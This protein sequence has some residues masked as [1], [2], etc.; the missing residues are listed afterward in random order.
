MLS[1]VALVFGAIMG[2]LILANIMDQTSYGMF[3]FPAPWKLSCLGSCQLSSS[4]SPCCAGVLFGLVGGI[5]TWIAIKELLP[6]AYRYDPTDT[7]ATCGC[8]AS[9][10]VMALSLVLF[11]QTGGHSH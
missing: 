11:M 10:A 9:M 8:I 5:M 4:E 7:V 3:V 1:A 2:W 6:T